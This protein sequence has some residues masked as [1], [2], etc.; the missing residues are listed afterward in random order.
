MGACRWRGEGVEGE[1]G[2]SARKQI[3]GRSDRGGATH[4]AQVES[5]D[6]SAE[7]EPVDQHGG[8]GWRRAEERAVDHQDPHVFRVGFRLLKQLLNSLRGGQR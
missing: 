1:G 4:A 2:E 6:V 5:L 3:E 8:E 7:V